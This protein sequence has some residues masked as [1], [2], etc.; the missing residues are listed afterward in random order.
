MSRVHSIGFVLFFWNVFLH[1]KLFMFR[2]AVGTA[3][4]SQ[5][6]VHW[7]ELRQSPTGHPQV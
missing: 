5:R 3:Q 1:V 4:Q 6:S 2:E 7:T